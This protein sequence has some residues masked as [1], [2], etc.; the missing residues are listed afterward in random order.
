MLKKL[1]S[2][3][4]LQFALSPELWN[5]IEKN[6]KQINL[7]KDEVL[8]PYSSKQKAV[9]L[10]LKGSLKQS[11]INSDGEK[12]A[13]WFFFEHIFNVAVCLDSYVLD[14]YTKYELIAL[15]ESTIYR[16]RKENVDLWANEFNEFNKFYLQDVLKSFF[17]A[18]EIRNH[19]ISH[20][21]VD[22]IQYLRDYYPEIIVKVPSKYLAEFM[23]ITPE[24]LS[25]LNKKLASV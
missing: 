6:A 20:T 18:T 10:V 2:R 19:L 23:G 15:E 3:L 17:L 21:P 1:K 5:E 12:T 22:F 4:E 16:I 24:W 11:L 7:N 25:K 9:Y 8:V 14:E 13:I